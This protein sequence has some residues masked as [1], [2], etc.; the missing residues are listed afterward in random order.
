MMRTLPNLLG[1]LLI[2]VMLTSM[3]HAA[4]QSYE[5]LPDPVQ[6][7]RAVQLGLQLR[8]MVCQMQSVNDSDAPLAKD[9]RRL[10]REQVSANQSDT[11]IL[12]Y[13]HR[14]YGDDILLKPPMKPVTYLLWAA[15][16][17]ML[18]LGAGGIWLIVKRKRV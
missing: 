10:I 11:A 6:E 16:L 2:S 1:G 8:C 7:A 5:Q 13:L 17:L 12:E 18:L 9:L 4:I 15:P 14:R 3:A